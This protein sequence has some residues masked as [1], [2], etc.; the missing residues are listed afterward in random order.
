MWISISFSGFNMAV[1]FCAVWRGS[2]WG[3]ERWALVVFGLFYVVFGADL[4]FGLVGGRGV[5]T[6]SFLR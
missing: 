1:A 5:A 4:A 2:L 6:L 3:V